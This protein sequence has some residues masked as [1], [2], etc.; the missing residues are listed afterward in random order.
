MSPDLGV[1][2][3]DFQLTLSNFFSPEKL[4]SANGGTLIL[5]YIAGLLTSFSPC[6]IGLLPL[7]LL[8]LGVGG[9]ETSSTDENEINEIN[10]NKRTKLIFY[11]L[12]ISI[13]FS[14]IGLSAASVGAV[15]GSFNTAWIGDI[16]KVLITVVYFVMGLNLL[17][18]L[19]IQFP[20]IDAFSKDSDSSNTDDESE[21]KSNPAVEAMIFGGS[22]AL[23]ASPCSSPGPNPNPN[24]DPDPNSNPNPNPDPDPDPDPNHK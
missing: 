16:F 17:E 18:I 20:S 19:N 22:S 1:A 4:S 5:L 11:A 21:S 23:I 9:S 3:Y 6:T 24:P 12:G 14:S 13:A 2:L 15:F 7:T 10:N 8:Y